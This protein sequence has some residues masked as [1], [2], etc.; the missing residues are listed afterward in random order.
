MLSLNKRTRGY[1]CQRAFIALARAMQLR[2]ATRAPCRQRN[3]LSALLLRALVPRHEA[4]LVTLLPSSLL[5]CH[6]ATLTLLF[7]G[8]HVWRFVGSHAGCCWRRT[9][10][11]APAMPRHAPWRRANAAS[12]T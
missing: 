3:D 7:N 6:S 2:M 1:E 12:V 5:Y 11:F 10:S 4:L 8:V 9:T